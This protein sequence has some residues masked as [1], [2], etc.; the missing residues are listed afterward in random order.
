MESS[1][2]SYICAGS[3]AKTDKHTHMHW[4]MY[5]KT[6]IHVFMESYTQ[7]N[8]Y[9]H[10]ASICT[11]KCKNSGVMYTFKRT[12]K[13]KIFPQTNSLCHLYTCTHHIRTHTKD[14]RMSPNLSAPKCVDLSRECIQF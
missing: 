6:H 2:H 12:D 4:F 10:K 3:N 8:A 14:K 5:A 9:V 7:T 11:H 1:T 13:G